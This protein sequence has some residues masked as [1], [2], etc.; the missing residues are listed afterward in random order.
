LG[1][2]GSWL[3]GYCI[4]RDEPDVEMRSFGEQPVLK[5]PRKYPIPQTRVRLADQKQSYLIVLCEL[6]QRVDNIRRLAADNLGVHIGREL[7]IV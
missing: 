1:G 7:E 3:C 4:L 5:G 6:D 2:A